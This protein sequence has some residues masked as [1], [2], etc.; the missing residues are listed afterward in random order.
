MGLSIP[1]FR[2]IKNEIKRALLDTSDHILSHVLDSDGNTVSDFG[3]NY[4][5]SALEVSKG[6]I[7]GTTFWHKFGLAPDFDTSDNTV[8]IWEGADDG[9]TNLMTYTFSTTADIDS[10]S[11]SDNADTQLIVVQGLDSNWDYVT[12]TITLTGQ[13]RKALTTSLIRVFRMYNMGATDF[14]GTIHC[15]VNVALTGGVP[16]TLTNIRAIV[17]NGNN[18]TLMTLYS[19]PNGKTAYMTSFFAATQGAKKATN[20][21]VNLWHRPF[22]SVFRIQ[23][24]HALDDNAT[25]HFNHK[26][27]IP[28]QYPAKTDFKWTAKLTEAAVTAASVG[29]G[30]EII[31]VD[32]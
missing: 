13:T 6:N 21:T 1:S 11:S 29:A 28:T 24:A 32:D 7:S 12:Q 18:Q 26:Y 16:D 5:N 25:S 15:F 17:K 27:N 3:G 14:A 30:Y 8:D 9:G 2:N 23:E 4:K 19:V 22:G 20:I 31:L 10:L